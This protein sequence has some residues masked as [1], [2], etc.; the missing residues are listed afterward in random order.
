MLFDMAVNQ[1]GSFARKALQQALNVNQ[2]G[3]IGNKTLTAANTAPRLMLITKLTRIRCQRYSN[4]VQKDNSQ[5]MFIE[6]WINRA[7]DILVEC[8]SLFFIGNN[9]HGASH[10]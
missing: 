10:D 4:L 7:F 2:D 5:L 6:G 3:I 1:G 9:S 8:Q